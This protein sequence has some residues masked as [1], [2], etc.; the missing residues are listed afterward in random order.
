MAQ[1]TIGIGTTANDGTGD[2]ARVA[3]DKINDNFTELYAADVSLASSIAGKANTSHTHLVANLSDA[4]DHAKELLQT[5]DIADFASSSHTHILSDIDELVAALASKYDSSHVGTTAYKLVQLTAAA[6]LPAVDGSLLTNL[7]TTLAYT[8]MA[9]FA[10]DESKNVNTKSITTNATFTFANPTPTV[11]TSTIL[12]VTNDA[13]DHTIT[14]PEFYCL[15]RQELITE[16]PI[17][18]SNTI[19]LSFI[20]TGSRW[21]SSSYQLNAF[22]VSTNSVSIGRRIGPNFAGNG[23]VLVGSNI[24]WGSPKISQLADSVV[25]GVSACATTTIGNGIVAIGPLT[26]A[27]ATE[28]YSNTAIGD[29]C[30]RYATGSQNTAVGYVAGSQHEAGDWNL[31]VGSYC[32][33]GVLGVVKGNHNILIGSYAG[34]GTLGDYNL[35][36][37]EYAGPQTGHAD[38]DYNIGVGNESMR[39]VTTGH[40]NV[41]IGIEAGSAVT[42]GT[43][44]VAIGYLAGSGSSGLHKVDLTNSVC[45]GYNTYNTKSNQ[46]VIGNSSV[47][48]TVLSGTLI[49]GSAYTSP[50]SASVILGAAPGK[51]PSVSIGGADDYMQLLFEKTNASASQLDILG[52]SV[53]HDTLFGNDSGAL[54]IHGHHVSN[55]IQSYAFFNPDGDV[56]F[57][58][59][60]YGPAGKVGINENSPDYKLDVNGTFGFTPGN[61]VTP[62][63][64]GDVVFELT[65]NTTL[66]IKAKGGDG[67]VRS[68][69]LTLA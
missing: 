5:Y 47:T 62:V 29:S 4:T 36:I 35:Y 34:D 41:G 40:H 3:G 64:N 7:S 69:A 44:S 50:G 19:E 53:R 10:I 56:V 39:Q 17:V 42:T 55:G 15:N 33:G 31:F 58:A 54:I 27:N 25:M 24:G 68:I 37:G 51:L 26:C 43:N 6:K 28:H 38:S 67:T 32:G 48:E 1:Q 20:Y 2:T 63:D 65:N 59:S 30:L 9:A 66:T 18:A 8:P 23:V 46:V 13:T 16:I 21:E 60:A 11:G 14:V 61:S 45:I 52:I 22:D 12:R 57:C 49:A